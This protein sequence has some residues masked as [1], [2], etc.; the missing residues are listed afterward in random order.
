MGVA[1]VCVCVCLPGGGIQKRAAE[2]CFTIQHFENTFV[3]ETK[4]C[5]A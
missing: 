4:I 5:K 2:E 3:T 1:N